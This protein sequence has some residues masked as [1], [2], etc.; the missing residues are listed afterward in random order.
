MTT[1]RVAAAAGIERP[2][3]LRIPCV[4]DVDPALAGE[5]LAVTRVPRRHDTVEHVDA[6]GHALDEVLRGPGSH[7]VARAI[8]RKPR[9]GLPGDLIHQVDRFAN[10]ESANRVPF[11]PDGDGRISTGVPQ[12]LEDTPLD[13]A[14]L[15]LPGIAYRD[16]GSAS[17]PQFHEPL[18][19]TGCPADRSLHRRGRRFARGRIREALVE[20]HGN[21]GSE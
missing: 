9:G 20:D 13:D 16:T 8:D 6:P 5:E 12:I 3:V 11:E 19:A 17:R 18:A 15:C 2:I 7:E 4:L 14:E 1:A 10:A 21:V